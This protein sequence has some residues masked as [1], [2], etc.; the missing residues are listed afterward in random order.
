MQPVDMM[1]GRVTWQDQM[2]MTNTVSE[3]KLYIS[4]LDYNV[5]KDDIKVQECSS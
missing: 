4:N 2:T 3:A 1:P 5:S